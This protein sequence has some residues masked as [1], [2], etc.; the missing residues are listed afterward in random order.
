VIN[1]NAVVEQQLPKGFVGSLT[2]IYTRGVHQ[3][4]ARNINA[5]LP[6]SLIRPFPDEGNVY[7]TES[8]ANSRYEG[9]VFSIQKRFG[10]RFNVFGNYTLSWTNNDADGTGS[11]PANSYDLHSE[12]GPAYTD[13]R[14]FLNITSMLSLPHG[15]R[16]TPFV[17]I[18]SGTPFNIMT[19]QDDNF[20]TVI[21]EHLQAST[22]MAIC[23]RAST[24]R[25]H[26]RSGI[27]R[28]LPNGVR[29]WSRLQN[30][31]LSISKTIGFGHRM[32]SGCR[33]SNRDVARAVVAVERWRRWRRWWS[34]WWRRRWLG[35]GGSGVPEGTRRGPEVLWLW[36]RS[37]RRRR[38]LR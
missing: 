37:S 27:S 29:H 38:V 3:F 7:Q 23:R 16:L 14:H 36:R 13:R 35:R 33:S 9:V 2:T 30:L 26:C 31:N 15:F 8:T 6:G 5:P 22:E 12:W 1:F 21:N 25:L 19:G 10:A 32:I 34:S 17:V 28:Q 18:S 20:D 4:R 24:R 11:L